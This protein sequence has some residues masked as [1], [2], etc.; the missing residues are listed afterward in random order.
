MRK[1]FFKTHAFQ[2]W[3]ACWE[4]LFWTKNQGR[5]LKT[6]TMTLRVGE[7]DLVRFLPS[8]GVVVLSPHDDSKSCRPQRLLPL[9]LLRS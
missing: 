7:A 4:I 5:A 9:F 3:L 1:V 8:L 2:I 6:W